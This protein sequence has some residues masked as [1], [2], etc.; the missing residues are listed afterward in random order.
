MFIYFLYVSVF[1]W[2]VVYN[3]QNERVHLWRHVQDI[4]TDKLGETWCPDLVGECFFFE[5]LKLRRKADVTFMLLISPLNRQLSISYHFL[6]PLSVHRSDSSRPGMKPYFR[7][8][9]RETV[10][11]RSHGL[12]SAQM[13]LLA[14]GTGEATDVVTTFAKFSWRGL[15]GLWQHSVAGERPRNP[16]WISKKFTL[17]ALVDRLIV[18]RRRR[19]CLC[20]II[21]GCRVIM[22]VSCAPIF[23]FWIS[24]LV[25][26]NFFSA[27]GLLRSLEAPRCDLAHVIAEYLSDPKCNLL[28]S[29]T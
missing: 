15:R 11:P 25:G 28:S 4:D 12:E 7:P 10:P 13:H 26:I 21:C 8:R 27:F 22:S 19:T 17:R 24:R 23:Y 20:S 14:L 1:M 2:F 5:D 18:E 9:S 29:R 16:R 6:S 3:L